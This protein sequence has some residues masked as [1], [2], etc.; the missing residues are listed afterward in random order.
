MIVDLRKARHVRRL[1]DEDY[2]YQARILCMDK[3]E[4]LNEMV[5]FQEDRNTKGA[6]SI[7]LIVRGRVLFKAL[8]D[9]AETPALVALSNSYLRHLEKE[10]MDYERA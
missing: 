1:K 3:L 5:K 9:T 6:L 2:A 10:A 4:L 7:D 8:A